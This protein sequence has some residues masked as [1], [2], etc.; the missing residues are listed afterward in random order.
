MASAQSRVRPT[1]A[2]PGRKILERR[3]ARRYGLSLPLAILPFSNRMAL[4]EQAG[5]PIGE[6]RDVST[7]GIYFTTEEALASGSE[8][9]FALILPAE[10]TS[11]RKVFVCAQAKVVRT[12]KEMKNG[13]ERTRVAALIERYE[14]VKDDPLYSQFFGG[15][16]ESVSSASSASL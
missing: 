12:E 4:H 13:I 1:F 8:L 7:G 9:V 5:F 10:L 15:K 11:G 6:T 3:S 2:R 16:T 14:I